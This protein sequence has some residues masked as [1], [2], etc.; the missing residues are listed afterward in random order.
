VA[1]LFG[2]DTGMRY[3]IICR[4]DIRVLLM[5]VLYMY[6]QEREKGR[7]GEKGMES[8]GRKG[9]ERKMVGVCA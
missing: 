8:P 1:L 7:K 9:V 3:G 6:P 2:D 4:F 5:L